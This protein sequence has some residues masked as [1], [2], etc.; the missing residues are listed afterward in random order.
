MQTVIGILIGFVVAGMVVFFVILL[1]TMRKL[2]AK[3]DEVGKVFGPLV[4]DGSIGR[5]VRAIAIIAELAPSLLTRFDGLTAVFEVFNKNFIDP[6]A[7]EA[8]RSPLPS[9]PA[10]PGSSFVGYDEE[11]QASHE[12]A[13]KAARY[14]IMVDHLRATP[15]TIPRVIVNVEERSARPEVTDFA[16]PV[17]APRREEPPAAEPPA[18]PVIQPPP[19]AP[20]SGAVTAEAPVVIDTTQP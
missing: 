17:V 5:S 12:V 9:V 16:P 18:V 4:A 2:A 1:M 19:P 10:A 6:R 7:G 20:R 14:G 8:F 13:A 11:A 15:P 3:F